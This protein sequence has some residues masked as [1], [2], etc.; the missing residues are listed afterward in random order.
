MDLS[1]ATRPVHVG[2]HPGMMGAIGQ[3]HIMKPAKYK[4]AG[5]GKVWIIVDRKRLDEGPSGEVI[6]YGE[7]MV[8]G[9]RPKNPMSGTYRLYPFG[10]MANP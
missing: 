9:G 10:D 1:D 3:N 5:I 7:G 8:R 6:R 4:A 2:I